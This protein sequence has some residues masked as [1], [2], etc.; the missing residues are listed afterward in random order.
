M[1]FSYYY[2]RIKTDA[3]ILKRNYSWNNRES[4]FAIKA[5]VACILS[6]LIAYSLD[7]HQGYWASISSLII[8]LP[9][10]GATAKKA[11]YRFFGTCFGAL[12][13]VFLSGLFCQNHIAYSIAIFLSISFCMYKSM[14]S[15][16]SYFWFL[17][18]VT[19]AIIMIGSIALNDPEQIIFIAFNRWFEVSV[20]IFVT[21]FLNLL[22]WPQYAAHEYHKR[23]VELRKNYVTF[24]ESVFLQYLEGSYNFEKTKKEFYAIKTEIKK[25]DELVEHA[26]FEIKTAR[27]EKSLIILDTVKLTTNL[28]HTWDFYLSIKKYTDL[29]FH[30]SYCQYAAFKSQVQL[31]NKI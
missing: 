12:I 21:S 18:A 15:R 2:N 9:S 1:S 27:R 16:Y 19:A 24:F 31:F 3:V 30:K 26:K 17:M 23:S 7:L 4:S 20:G 29:S 14:F 28:N 22:V 11:L 6:M 8:M 5:A 10:A 13:A 25:I